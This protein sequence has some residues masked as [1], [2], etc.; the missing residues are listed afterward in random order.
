M[1]NPRLVLLD[2]P[3][4]DL[5]PEERIRLR[6]LLKGIGDGR[7]VVVSTHLLD[8]VKAVCS[9]VAVLDR[10]RTGFTGLPEDVT[11]IAADRV[12]ELP[13]DASEADAPHQSGARRVIAET[14]PPGAHPVPPTMEEGYTALMRDLRAG[15]R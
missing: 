6:A 8:D 11:E 7:T 15:G 9:E 2:E 12:F 3:T 1:G 13:R 5:D 4:A 10:G 14:P